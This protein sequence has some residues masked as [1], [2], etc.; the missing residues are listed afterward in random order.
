MPDDIIFSTRGDYFSLD[1]IAK[2]LFIL[3]IMRLFLFIMNSASV[4]QPITKKE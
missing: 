2:N 3:F 4:N 1:W